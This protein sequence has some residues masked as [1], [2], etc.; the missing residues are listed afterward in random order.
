VQQGQEVALTMMRN[1]YVVNVIQNKTLKK[2]QKIINV[3][4]KNFI[5]LLMMLGDLEEGIIL[6]VY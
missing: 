2:N 4:A 1:G 3:F 6:N 5:C